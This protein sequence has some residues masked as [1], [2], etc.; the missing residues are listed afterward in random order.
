MSH[1]TLLITHI[2][3]CVFGL[4]VTIA[5]I[6]WPPWSNSV[7][8]DRTVL[9]GSGVLALRRCW[10]TLRKWQYQKKARS[11]NSLSFD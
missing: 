9:C 1:F 10:S 8:L 6:W 2:L 11:L 3:I 4:K 7:R 5:A